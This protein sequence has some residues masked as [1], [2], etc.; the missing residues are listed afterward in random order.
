MVELSNGCICCTLREDLLT[1]LTA[2]AAERR[3]D[4]VLV[5]ST[6]ISEPLPVAETFTFDDAETGTRL[7]DVAKLHN[8]VTVVDA[9][10]IFE[11]LATV[12]TLVDRGWQ[13]GADDERTV[14]HLLVDQL[15]FSD[16][17]LLNKT[18]LVTATRSCRTSRRWSAHRRA[19]AIAPSPSLRSLCPTSSRPTP[20]RTTWPSSL[21]LLG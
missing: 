5:E 19:R 4:H 21:G 6:G 17:V 13:A 11:Q 1:S 10:G 14:A 8:L 12:D 7:G 18:D 20:R 3:F 9:A 16:V 2:L 15:E